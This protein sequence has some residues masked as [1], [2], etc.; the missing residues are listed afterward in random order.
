M[1]CSV[2][3]FEL[4]PYHGPRNTAYSIVVEY[5]PPHSLGR[6]NRMLQG[7]SLF[8]GIVPYRMT[9]ASKLP[10]VGQVLNPA[11]C[12]SGGISSDSNQTWEDASKVLTD[13]E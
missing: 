10:V 2:L 6:F 9:K 12:V 3:A 11:F 13:L 8:Q 7:L 1:L 5:P 4:V